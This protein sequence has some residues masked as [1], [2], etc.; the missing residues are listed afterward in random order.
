M[1]GAEKRSTIDVDEIDE[2]EGDID[3]HFSDDELVES[4]KK[5]KRS[6]RKLSKNV[7]YGE[8]ETPKRKRPKREGGAPRKRIIMKKPVNCPECDK[9]LC[10]TSS[11][12]LHMVTYFCA[13]GFFCE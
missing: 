6:K 5:K 9:Q 13:I 2:D 1:T 10:D 11:L 4:P 7:N 3:P 8:S 12:K